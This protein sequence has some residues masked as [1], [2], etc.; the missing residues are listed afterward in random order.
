MR[1]AV[2]MA[3][4]SGICFGIAATY[5][6]KGNLTVGINVGLGVVAALLTAAFALRSSDDK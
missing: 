2:G 1:A 6:Y 3:L 5:G 4:L